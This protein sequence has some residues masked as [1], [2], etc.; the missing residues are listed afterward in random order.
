[1]GWLKPGEKL[2][3]FSFHFMQKINHIDNR[4]L[5]CFIISCLTFAVMLSMLSVNRYKN[6]IASNKGISN[7]QEVLGDYDANEKQKES[8][9]AISQKTVYESIYRNPFTG[10]RVNPKYFQENRQTPIAVMIDNSS[11]AWKMQHNI[12]KADI[13]YESLTE[14]GITRLMAI[15]YSADDSTKIM[16]VRSI[17]NTFLDFYEEYEGVLLY[18]VGGAHTPGIPETDAV[19]RVLDKDLKSIYYY[20]G[21]LYPF[22]SELYDE[23]CTSKDIPGYSCKYRHLYEL[24]DQAVSVDLED[25]KWSQKQHQNIMW[26]YGSQ[27]DFTEYTKATEISYSFSQ[28]STQEYAVSWKYNAEQQFYEK[29]TGGEAHIDQADGKQLHAKNIFVLKKKHDFG[30]DDEHRSVVHSTGRGDGYYIVDGKL[31]LI[32]WE[33]ECQTCRT[34]FYNPADDTEILVQ[35]GRT[36]ISVIDDA[37]EVVYK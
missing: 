30:V 4:V 2:K 1:M 6:S 14:W 17:R 27:Q 3:R 36:W 10:E 37:Q 19:G 18:H 32:E 31:R 5:A 33:K 9:N 34:R 29:F 12:N 26:K 21:T 25:Y 23:S 28:F 8:N 13:V 11:P 20:Q 22:F 16:P 15:Y 24:R 35:P 7:H